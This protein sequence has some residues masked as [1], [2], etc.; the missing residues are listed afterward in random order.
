MVSQG[1]PNIGIW[2]SWKQVDSNGQDLNDTSL[3]TKMVQTNSYFDASLLYYLEESDTNPKSIQDISISSKLNGY[4]TSTYRWESG[5]G[6]IIGTTTVNKIELNLGYYEVKI[7]DGTNIFTDVPN[8]IDGVKNGYTFKGF[9]GDS[10]K[11]QSAVSKS[12]FYIMQ[13]VKTGAYIGNETSD[14]CLIKNIKTSTFTTA[15][16]DKLIMY[17]YDVSTFFNSNNYIVVDITKHTA[18]LP[19]LTS[20]T[21]VSGKEYTFTVN[22]TPMSITTV[23]VYD[24]DSSAAATLKNAVKNDYISIYAN[25]IRNNYIRVGYFEL[26]ES[27]TTPY[28]GVYKY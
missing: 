13:P 17:L 19:D 5:D 11:F 22:S 18:Y 1:L 21:Y 3:M 8:T 23:N 9:K 15:S 16:A 10:F 28:C 27:T 6:S 24:P 14:V 20:L 7:S 26:K 25:S 4:D 12:T 2:L